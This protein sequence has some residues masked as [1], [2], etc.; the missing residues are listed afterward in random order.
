MTTPFD[1]FFKVQ[2]AFWEGWTRLMVNN[3]CACERLFEHQTKLLEHHNYFRFHNVI[4]RGADWLDH[5]GKRNR[6]VDVEKV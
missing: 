2:I 4:P 3:A 1:P 5:Y 6:D